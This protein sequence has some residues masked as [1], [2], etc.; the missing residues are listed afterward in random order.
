[1][2]SVS[3]SFSGAHHIPRFEDSY[4]WTRI[5][6]RPLRSRIG[7]SRGSPAQRTT[8]AELVSDFLGRPFHETAWKQW[9]DRDDQ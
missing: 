9:L 5:V 6:A 2:T 4:A 1:M 7:P 3:W 8:G